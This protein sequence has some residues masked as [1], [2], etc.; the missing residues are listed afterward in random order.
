LNEEPA[1]FREVFAD[2][3]E[4]RGKI[5]YRGGELLL[6]TLEFCLDIRWVRQDKVELTLYA[7]KHVTLLDRDVVQS[8]KPAILLGVPDRRRAYIDGYQLAHFGRTEHG[9]HTASATEVQH[10]VTLSAIFGT[11]I[12]VLQ[13][14][15]DVGKYD[16]SLPLN[17]YRR[18]N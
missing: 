6:L 5:T 1:I 7:R 13:R 8:V 2:L 11:S 4:K 16:Q 10:P 14:L 9:T 17:L 15:I 18:P 12:L 3:R